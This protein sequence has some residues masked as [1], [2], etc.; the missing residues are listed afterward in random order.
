MPVLG[1]GGK[2]LLQREA[3][4][5]CILLSDAFNW[6]ANTLDLDC[7]DDYWSGDQVCLHSPGGLPIADNGV[8]GAID[9]VA[10]YF[11]SRWFLGDN[12]THIDAEDD[13]FYKTDTE[14][15]PAGQF[16]DDANFYFIGGD[17][18]GDGTVDDNDQITDRCYYIH[19]D[20]MGRVSF[21]NTR[22]EAL[23]GREEDRV[24]LINVDFDY[25]VLGP[26]GSLEYNNALWECVAALGDYEF[27][28]VQ[29]NGVIP[30]DS[31]CDHPPDYLIPEF[32][33]VELE[34]ADVRPRGS[35][36][37]Y[38]YWQIMCGIREWSLELDA[39]SVDTTSVGEKFGEAVKSLVTGGGSIDFFVEKQCCDDDR[40]SDGLLIMQ[41]LLMTE[42]GSKAHA[43][44]Y[45]IDRGAPSKNCDTVQKC[46]GCG[47]LPGDL[48]YSTDILV[49]RN[50]VNMRPTDLVAM[51]GNFVTTGEIKLLAT[52]D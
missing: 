36:G 22:C 48:Y 4:G 14:Q 50:A 13:E 46:G 10:T 47:D 38:P 5:P 35:S 28:D 23:L 8:P 52:P 19:I 16:G 7:R 44:F 29:E 18:N 17:S 27:S 39:P 34:N 45:L 32:S 43:E 41:L 25:I 21:Y 2:L 3:P 37:A 6:D 31:I 30:I 20:Q 24:D 42:K 51:T 15:Y 49:T 12:R 40:I 9:G 11:G 1:C 26:Y 33:P